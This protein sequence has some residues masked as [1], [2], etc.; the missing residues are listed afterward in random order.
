VRNRFRRFFDS[1][2][3]R[4]RDPSEFRFASLC[5]AQEIRVKYAKCGSDFGACTHSVFPI[6]ENS[7]TRTGVIRAANREC[8]L[9]NAHRFLQA[10]YRR[11]VEA[12]DD[13]HEGIE[14]ANVE[15]LPGGLD[16]IFDH[17]N[18]LLLL[19]MLKKCRE[20]ARVVRRGRH[21]LREP[22]VSL[23][24]SVLSDS[25]ESFLSRYRALRKEGTM[26]GALTVEA[27]K[28][29]CSP[30]TPPSPRSSSAC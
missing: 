16:P 10:R 3:A 7:E 18:A 17:A 21:A 5:I 9:I 28:P 11:H 6:P 20:M 23:S 27:I 12:S 14:V 26:K 24:L 29:V 2:V 22:C 1:P 30:C 8:L 4:A 19:R 15:A 13:R 25:I